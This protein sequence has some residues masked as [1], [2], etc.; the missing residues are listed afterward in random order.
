MIPVNVL[1]HGIDVPPA[2]PLELR[3]GPLTMRFMRESGGLRDIRIG[4]SEV[5]NS[6]YVAVR[7]RNW[8][9]VPTTLH[10]LSVETGDEGFRVTFQ[11]EC[12]RREID[13]L[14][15]GII[16]ASGG[17]DGGTVSEVRFSMDGRA[18]STFLRSRIG[19]CVLHGS[20]SCAGRPCTVERTD[21][22]IQRGRFP[23]LVSPHQ[24]F[25]NIQAVKHEVAPGVEAEVRFEGDVFEMEDQRN[26]TDASFKT[27]CTPLEL[28][29]PV[30][31]RAGTVVKQAVT[32]R[33]KQTQNAE[34]GT[35]DRELRNSGPV[36]IS[37]NWSAPAK[38]LPRIGFGASAHGKGLTEQEISRLRALRPAHLRVDLGLSD[39]NWETTLREAAAQAGALG[40][41]IEAA[42]LVS[43]RAEEELRGL[44]SVVEKLR[45][46]VSAWLI[47]H[48]KLPA[49]P[50]GV[51]EVAREHLATHTPG[52]KFGSGSNAN[53]AELNRNTPPLKMLDIVCY[54]MNPQV[55]TFDDESMMETLAGQADTVLSAR[56]LAGNVPVA[57]T[58]VTLKPRFNAAATG[59][60]SKP[61]GDELPPQ[62]DVRQMSLLG[63]AWTLGSM[64]RLFESGAD[65]V[66]YYETTGWRGVMETERG[67]P[68]PELFRSLPGSV[69][70]MYH[71]FADV[72]E[73]A[74]GDLV[75]LVSSDAGRVEGLAL[76][77]GDRR[78]VLLTNLTARPQAASVAIDRSRCRAR[79]LDETNA[80]AAMQSPET[81][82]GTGESVP[83]LNGGVK[84]ELRPYAVI[85][86]HLEE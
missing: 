57:V 45:P 29:F 83:A 51:I 16:E 64:K 79:A 61:A 26:W 68:L 13:F 55:H 12:R 24:P 50:E 66:T 73:F 82:R 10:D 71:V 43:D 65:S 69:F 28:P 39:P 37:V 44:A 9:T 8:G 63:A 32:L 17:R 62:V 48:Q 36:S 14:W 18:R 58:P 47:L 53:F 3:A 7:D 11:A 84:L 22:S 85:Y 56:K 15:T 81:Y 6:I 20:G 75:P 74:G 25:K 77:K 59:N 52:A 46:P 5:L 2:S 54:P 70:P 35:R 31:I 41:L 42:I 19:I 34:S 33:V 72:A 27:Y 21:G 4:N 86:I 76:R 67:S 78:I 80:V 40:T 38:P 30:E 60:A 1:Y 49:V 23:E